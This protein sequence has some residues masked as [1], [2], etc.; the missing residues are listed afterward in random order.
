M[1][2]LELWHSQNRLFK[3]FQTYLGTTTNIQSCSGI[4]R[5]IKHNEEYSGIIK[6]YGAII[7]HIG[8]SALPLHIQLCQIQNHVLFRTRGVF[9]V[10]Q[11]CKMIKHIQSPGIAKHFQGYLTI[12][13]DIEAYSSTLTDMQLERRGETSPAL[14]ENKKSAKMLE[15]KALILSII[16]LNFPFKI[17]I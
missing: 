7:R 17:Y 8:N 11:T 6:V 9:K 13:R 10:C 15:I 3:N 16:G 2:Y 14:F 4:L 12:F 1:A 5:D